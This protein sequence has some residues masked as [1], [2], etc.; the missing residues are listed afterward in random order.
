MSLAEKNTHRCAR[1][2]AVLTNTPK[3]VPGLGDLGPEC[4]QHVAGL[5]KVFALFDT[6]LDAARASTFKRSLQRL[7]IKYEYDFRDADNMY[8]VEYRYTFAG[9][10]QATRK[11]K[12]GT[13][14]FAQNRADFA[15]YLQARAAMR[16][17]AA[18]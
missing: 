10:K 16:H 8:G 15:A 13:K 14:T 17:E 18:A 2:G 9:F 4:Y 7:G 3:H 11:P 5:E 12:G 6:W 1:C